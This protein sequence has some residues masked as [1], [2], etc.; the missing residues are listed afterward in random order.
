MYLHEA[1]NIPWT[2]TKKLAMNILVVDSDPQSSQTICRCIESSC[3]KLMVASDAE[4]AKELVSHNGVSIVILNWNLHDD[5][6]HEFCR[7]LRRALVDQ[8]VY[9]LGISDPDI[10]S[11]QRVFDASVDDVL[12]CPIDDKE[13]TSRLKSAQRIVE[14]QQGLV[15]KNRRLAS[16]FDHLMKDFMEVTTDLADAGRVQQGLLP[17][18]QQYENIN[19]H[20]V[21]RPATQLSGDSFDFFPLN[22]RY[23]A[24]YIA[25]A[26]GHGSASAMVSYALHHQVKP[27]AHGICEKNMRLSNSIEEAVIK[28]VQDLNDQFVADIVE[29]NRWF[30]MIYGLIEMSTGDVTLCQAGQPPALHFSSDEQSISEIGGGGFPVGLF[31]E[32]TYTTEELV[33]LPGDKLLLCSDGAVECKSSTE[34]EFGIENIKLAMQNSTGMDLPETA[35]VLTDM[36]VDWNGDEKFDDDLSVLLFQYAA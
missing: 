17:A 2:S 36:L 11:V 1:E 20:G 24:F 33:L 30:T 22:D 27:R 7:W 19:A 3:R 34:Q 31:E 13:L 16:S 4:G 14:F 25:D 9:V 18:S 32:A 15:K 35:V 29:S 12:R 5:T 6:A 21:L 10:D 28:T 26:V 8:Y 23:L